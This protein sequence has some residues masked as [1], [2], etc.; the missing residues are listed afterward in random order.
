[1][2]LLSLYN[3]NKRKFFQ[4]AAFLLSEGKEIHLQYIS[5][6]LQPCKENRFS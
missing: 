2:P 3:H 1:M 6:F 5:T 4:E